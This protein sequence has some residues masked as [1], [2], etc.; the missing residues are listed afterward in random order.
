MRLSEVGIV[1]AVGCCLA[2]AETGAP[3]A[4]S[5]PDGAYVVEYPASWNHYPESRSLYI[6]S[7]PLNRIRREI[8]LPK[9]GAMITFANTRPQAGSLEEW[10][11]ADVARRGIDGKHEFRVDLEHQR[12][13]V[14]VTETI[15]HSNRGNYTFEEVDWYFAL[16]GR[17]FDAVLLYHKGDPNRMEYRRVLAKVVTSIRVSPMPAGR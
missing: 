12:F 8:L 10:I 13:P 15:S 3:K 7:F 16:S 11:G 2:Q 1:F 6:L 4:F 9:N 14:A 17:L 5:S